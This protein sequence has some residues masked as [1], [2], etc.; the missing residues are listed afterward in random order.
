MIFSFSLFAQDAR[1]VE[2]NM[3]GRYFQ[4]TYSGVDA[5]TL[6]TNQDT[7]DIIFVTA[8]EESIRSIHISSKFDTIA[9]ADTVVAISILGEGF[10]GAGYTTLL[11]SSNSTA[12]STSDQYEYD[13]AVYTETVASYV[14]TSDS[15]DTHATYTTGAQTVTPVSYDYKRIIVRYIYPTAGSFLGSGVKLD[16]LKI[17]FWV[18]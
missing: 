9:V 18:Y 5:D 3:K 15:T 6:T 7:I 10:D 17:R 12:I 1:E 4:Y 11:A 8:F 13:D 16:E 2:K 14:L